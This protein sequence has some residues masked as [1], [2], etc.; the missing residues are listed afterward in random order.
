[1][2]LIMRDAVWHFMVFT[3]QGWLDSTFHLCQ[4]L[5]GQTKSWGELMLSRLANLF[6][7]VFVCAVLPPF[8]TLFAQELPELR[9][10]MSYDAARKLLIDGGWQANLGN[11]M[12]REELQIALTE[13]YVKKGYLEVDNCMPTGLGLCEASFKDAAGNILSISINENETV[14]SW[15]YPYVEPSLDVSPDPTGDD[16]NSQ[17]ASTIQQAEPSVAPNEV[18]VRIGN[19]R[20]NSIHVVF[21]SQVGNRQ[22]PGGT[23][24]FVVK[25]GTTE[26][27]SLSCRPQEQI[28]MGAAV[29]LKRGGYGRY[30]GVSLN[31]RQRCT[32]C[33][34]QCGSIYDGWNL[35]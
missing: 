24:V 15:R 22:W 11:P 30:W 9:Q 18:R 6:K 20:K 4:F 34:F 35:Q 33:C 28:C 17:D 19:S 8:S 1:M 25:P 26:N 2:V 21:F 32:S 23:Q 3:V 10:G 16:F 14:N 5:R 12:H 13:Y 29:P 27:Y 7:F 31:G